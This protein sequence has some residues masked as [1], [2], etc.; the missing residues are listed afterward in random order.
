LRVNGEGPKHRYTRKE[1][2]RLLELPPTVLDNWEQR[3]FIEQREDYGFADLIALRTLLQ[4]RRARIRADQV[5][6]ILDSLRVK[7]RHVA[8]PLRELKVSVDGRRVAVQ[9]DGQKMEPLSGQLL[10]D[11][12]RAELNR[13]LRFPSRKGEEARAESQRRREAEE[14]FDRGLEF[15]QVEEKSDEAAT[16]YRKAIDLDPAFAPALVNLGTLHYHA[17]RWTDAEECYRQ[18]LAV[19]P[20]Y[21]LAHFNLGNLMEESGYWPK[22]REHYIEAIRLQP[23]YA[24][25]HYNLALLFQNHG[26]QL[27]A[28]RHWQ[29]YLKLDPAGYWASIA[30]RELARLRQR[31]IVDGP[32]R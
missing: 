18:A 1:V 15:E 17:R 7:L 3:G 4:L 5:R 8:H 23:D 9:V 26:E 6:E 31:A 30:R 14:W 25:A 13:L 21:A 22:A 32:R 11:F 29:A 16:A 28:V 10:L 27:K 19:R 24:D 12:D 20:D 2:C